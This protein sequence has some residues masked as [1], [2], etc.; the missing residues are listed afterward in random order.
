VSSNSSD[1]DCPQRSDYRTISRH[2]LIGMLLVVRLRASAVQRQP[3]RLCARF[4]TSSPP[5]P[6][7]LRSNSKGGHSVTP[8]KFTRAA[9]PTAAEN[10]EMV[11]SSWPS[12][13]PLSR[14]DLLAAAV[15]NLN[16]PELEFYIYQ[17]QLALSLLETSSS[18]QQPAGVECMVNHRLRRASTAGATDRP[19]SRCGIRSIFIEAIHGHDHGG[20]GRDGGAAH[21]AAKD[22]DDGGLLRETFP[23]QP[24]GETCSRATQIE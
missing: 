8:P 2:H 6:K 23:T 1:P 10:S 4:R 5:K 15:P 11:A 12:P 22:G 14:R 16:Y 19:P 20:G 3:Q 24:A 9:H 18:K 21:V 17:H 7:W 13:W